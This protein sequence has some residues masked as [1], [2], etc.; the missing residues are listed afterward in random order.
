MDGNTSADKLDAKLKNGTIYQGEHANFLFNGYGKIIYPEGTIYEGKFKSG[1]YD[2]FGKLILVSG[3]TYEG[4]FRSG[5]Y[6]G[7][8]YYKDFSG[9]SYS[10][11]F[12]QGKF[13][14]QGVLKT[15]LGRIFR[16]HFNKGHQDGVGI[17]EMENGQKYTGEILNEEAN[18]KGELI[19]PDG[20][21]YS[22]SF[23]DG[24]PEGQI[25]IYF[26]D[27]ERFEGTIQDGQ[28]QGLGTTFYSDGSRATSEYLNGKRG[29][30]VLYRSDGV[31]FKLASD[32]GIA[33]TDKCFDI[34]KIDEFGNSFGEVT[35]DESADA[36][37]KCSEAIKEGHAEAA[38]NL[39]LMY[40]FGRGVDVNLDKAIEYYQTALKMNAE[41]ISPQSEYQLGI[42][43]A[44]LYTDE[45]HLKIAES[46]LD[47]ALKRENSNI[48]KLF[49]PDSV[50]FK[51]LI[52]DALKS[53]HE[54]LQLNFKISANQE[55]PKNF[56]IND[57]TFSNLRWL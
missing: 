49:Y 43:F 51:V 55:I 34:L 56:I 23:K 30:G 36:F 17:I 29:T 5:H 12:F 31:I 7:E 18:G 6:S 39:G 40:Q 48:Y 2:G 41:P 14:G 50:S 52:K 15:A 8:G 24:R 19:L 44:K 22:G 1:E 3:S 38:A 37:N 57:N 16:G 33:L 27:R 26:P 25:V 4:Q 42:L 35:S 9:F 28:M 10:G 32:R 11:D 54:K 20:V 47:S 45:A 46:F 53:I 21:K 13:D